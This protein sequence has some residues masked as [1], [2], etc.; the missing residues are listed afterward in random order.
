M[1]K[2]YIDKFFAD[3]MNTTSYELSKILFFWNDD[4]EDLI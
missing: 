3:N 1:R 4:G 2:V